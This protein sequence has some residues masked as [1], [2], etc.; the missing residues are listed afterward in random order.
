M[1][2]VAE[3]KDTI[4]T[5]AVDMQYV[6]SVPKARGIAV[7]SVGLKENWSCLDLRLKRA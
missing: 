4:C 2:A 5:V 6:G 3:E 7:K 1:L